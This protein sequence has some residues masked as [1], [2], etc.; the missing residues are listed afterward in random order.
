MRPKRRKLGPRNSKPRTPQGE[1]IEHVRTSLSNPKKT[2]E[3]LPIE[4]L[5]KIFEYLTLKELVQ[6]GNTCQRWKLIISHAEKLWLIANLKDRIVPVSFL[7]HLCLKGTKYLSL[8]WAR[9][10]KDEEFSDIQESKLTHLNLCDT[11]SV[12]GGFGYRNQAIPILEKLLKSCHSVEKLA[13]A[14]LR[15][16]PNII[17]AIVQNASTLTVLNLWCCKELTL[18]MIDVMFTNCQ[19][20]TEVNIP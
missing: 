16:N 18:N 11:R 5:N 14:K 10:I 8:Q 13:L 15:L 9:L 1:K 6:C 4:I 2:H 3:N 19:E 20:L 12:L 17:T 7:N